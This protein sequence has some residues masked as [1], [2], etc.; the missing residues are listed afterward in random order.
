MKANYICIWWEHV[1]SWSWCGCTCMFICVTD[2]G[3]VGSS[4]RCSPHFLN[5]NFF[6][7]FIFYLRPCLSLAWNLPTGLGWLASESQESA[8][9][10]LLSSWVSST[11]H[12]VDSFLVIDY[13]K[14]NVWSPKASEQGPLNKPQSFLSFYMPLFLFLLSSHPLRTAC[15]H[16]HKDQK[17]CGET[18]PHRCLYLE[19]HMVRFRRPISTVSAHVMQEKKYTHR[20]TSTTPVSAQRQNSKFT[21]FRLALYKI[22]RSQSYGILLLAP[23]SITE[24]SAGYPCWFLHSNHSQEKN[25]KTKKQNSLLQALA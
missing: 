23:H 24:I 18:L 7:N 6:F 25:K 22:K 9:P 19:T 14:C 12:R 2:R 17:F 21:E 10:H 20:E 4:L 8:H 16:T 5:L 3:Q 11:C 15:A 1:S 13:M